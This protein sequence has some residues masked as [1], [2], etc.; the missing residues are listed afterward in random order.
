MKRN[1]LS[2]MLGLCLLC[3]G[4][5]RTFA[6][7]YED[8]WK[9]VK[10]YEKKDL[11]KSAYKVVQQIGAK[12]ERENVKGQ[13]LAALAHGCMLRQQIMP[14]SFYTDMIMLERRKE[15][16][17]DEVLR[18][19]Y[20]SVLGELYK[21]NARRNRN[22]GQTK[23]HPDSLREW[24]YDQFMEASAANYRLSM[25]HPEL[26]A[27]VKAADFVPF[28]VR[29]EDAVYFD[30]D[31]LNV[32]GRRAV[33]SLTSS[34]HEDRR[35]VSAAWYGDMLKVYRNK[36]NRRAELL[37]M[38]DSLA[39]EKNFVNFRQPVRPNDNMLTDEDVEKNVLQSSLYKTYAKMLD[40]FGDL[41]LSAQIYIALTNLP[42]TPALKVKWAEEGCRK[43]PDYPRVA[44]L[45]NSIA[46]L[47]NPCIR[48]TLP[49][50]VYPE[51]NLPCEV[52]HRNIRGAELRW[53]LM[54][55]T[56][57]AQRLLDLQR[58]RALKATALKS[59]K[60]VKKQRLTW[61]EA[62]AY[63][64]VRDTLPLEVP[65]I[66]GYVVVMRPDGVSSAKDEAVGLVGA[67]RL[68][69][70]SLALPD[71]RVKVCVVDAETGAPVPSATVTAKQNDKVY[72]TAQTDETGAAYFKQPDG[73]TYYSRVLN[74]IAVKGE[75]KYMLP[76]DVYERFA[77]SED[78]NH[79]DIEQLYTD[80]SI[81]RPGQ[82]VYVGGLCFSRDGKDEKAESGR[83]LLLTLH[84]AN[85]KKIAER[86]AKSDEMG[87]FSTDF[88]LP[89]T[90]LN[91]T[92]SV[93]TSR[94]SVRFTVE[95]YKRPTFDVTLQPVTGIF[96]AGDTVMLTGK[97][98]NLT[99]VPVRQ[100]RVTGSSSLLCW[101][102]SAY[103]P[104]GDAPLDTV[105]TND[106]G[107][108]VMPVPI[109]D[110]E[111]GGFR[112]GFRQAVRI[113]AMNGAGETHE[114]S[115]VLPLSKDG[116]CIEFQAP[117]QWEKSSLP[118]CCPKPVT[119]TGEAVKDSVVMTFDLFCIKADGH[120][121]AV[122]KDRAWPAEKTV[123]TVGF[124]TLPVGRYELALRAVAAEDTASLTHKF[125]LFDRTDARPVEG[126]TDWFHVVCDTI[127]PS[128]PGHLQVG[129][130]A[131]DVTLY[132]TLFCKD[133]VLKDTVYEFSDSVLK[134]KYPYDEAYGDGLQAHFVFVKDGK[135]YHHEEM[136]L[137]RQPERELRFEWTT[138]RDRLQPGTAETWKLRVLT[139]DSK[140]AS[141]QVMAAMYDASLDRIKPHRWYLNHYIPKSYPYAGFNSMEYSGRWESFMS[142]T[143]RVRYIS[144]KNFSFDD[145]S[146]GRWGTSYNMSD[147][148]TR[149][150]VL[151][152]CENAAFVEEEVFA[153]QSLQGAVAGVASG[154]KLMKAA[155][156]TTSKME[157]VEAEVAQDAD[158][159]ET[160]D[161]GSV[162]LR[163]NL[164]ETAFF[165]PRLTPD[166]SG[167]FTIAFT[168][169]ESL[170]EWKFM[171]LA[172]TKDMM[173]GIF[174][175]KVVAAKEV[176][177]QLHL[178]RFVRVGDRATLSASL[179]NLTENAL[180]GRVT[181][182]VFDP[183]TGKSLWKDACKLTLEAE[184]DTVV[185]FG[186]TPR[187]GVSLPACRVMFEAGS[188]TDGEQRYL[189]VLAD[190]EWLTQTLP[191][192]VRGKGLTEIKLDGLFQNNH[193]NATGR[194]LTV[195]YTANPLWYAVQALPSV[196]EP[197]TDDAVSLGAA[198]Y[199]SVLSTRLATQ[200]PQLKTVTAEW[201]RNGQEQLKSP[202]ETQE[203]LKGILLDETPWLTDA[204]AETR[205]MQ[206]LQQLFDT[207]RQNDLQR[208]FCENL[209]KLQ[210]SDGGFSWFRGM[211]SSRY[212]TLAVAQLF[213]RA[214]L[215]TAAQTPAVLTQHVDVK[216]MMG[217]LT[218]ELHE[219]VVEDR[220]SVREHKTH[221][222]SGHS[223]LPFLYVTGRCD[224][225]LIG[226]SARAD[227]NYAMS[228][229]VKDMHGLDM[230]DK[231]RAAT[232][233]QR[234]G[235]KNEAVQLVRSLREHLVETS[236]GTHLEYYSNGFY[237]SEQK[238]DTHVFIMEA[239][240]A[241]GTAG[242]DETDGLCRWLLG[243]KQ[244]QA[245][246]TPVNS[247]N[248]VYAL[249]DMQHDQLDIQANDE[250]RVLSSKGEEWIRMESGE[251]E[252]AGLGCVSSSVSGKELKR[253]AG[254]V[255]VNKA[256]EQPTAWGAAYAQ[257][258]LPLADIEA[259]A[260]GV[261]IRCEV[262]QTS[263]KVG[264]RVI[265]RYVIT[266]DRDYEYVC[267][268]AGRAACLEPVESRTGYEYD[269]GLG[270]YKEVRDAS[271]NYFF[272][273]LPKGTYVLESEQYVE[274]PGV[275]TLGAAKLNGVYAPEFS[276][277]GNAPVLNV[278][279]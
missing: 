94:G 223:W 117:E 8:L 160:G 45:K 11:P 128:V 218:A 262:S 31:L 255:A 44:M 222:Y 21:Q 270:Y 122:W 107:T 57:S 65:G 174:T 39:V 245:W 2:A 50:Q 141:A 170:T 66:G 91:G 108:F 48:F 9:Q 123:E 207:N 225:G 158:G 274:R 17:G 196:L 51:K 173:S 191:F 49:G 155:A 102:R 85:G 56:L 87:K 145:F 3:G 20:A 243:Q 68:K 214:G 73:N 204:E 47:Q 79:E 42:V 152:V 97:V 88:V 34:A 171:A 35:G 126:M 15:N 164:N 179:F 12:A 259:Q 250:V 81:Y 183:A 100:A 36:G 133:K 109:R 157:V 101:F 252:L 76:R 190:K 95:E 188:Y 136:L 127:S 269:N 228:V 124:G 18:A 54:P 38:L 275:Y 99:G 244:V 121:E 182:E 7:S 261:S 83:T 189:P 199:A 6:A 46:Q 205:R 60:L 206:S 144:Y 98:M 273:R 84:D 112:F 138:F 231:A 230:A 89:S 140:P 80:R 58:K 242:A 200:Y 265:L 151:S 220:K 72:A 258:M 55:S 233:M 256:E 237:T 210:N 159:G 194:R 248:A 67:T 161:F 211:R 69:M 64:D 59:G 166:E 163:E 175:D 139:P 105:Y 37:V 75:D 238:I 201:M 150:Q 221:L 32:I 266:A 142:Y 78:K 146:W 29:G 276:A 19:V 111:D 24:S 260:K 185:M 26:L 62:A 154:K 71:N 52:F 28:V 257:F 27:E 134:F 249:M 226:T 195:E 215:F 216:K 116:L 277:Y 198:L 147:M 271:T 43:Y 16:A 63:E 184:A 103:D 129:S 165:Y 113:L 181:I 193:P 13:Q 132:Y 209:G 137:M 77:Y 86:E 41:S 212:I 227:L 96:H 278:R 130:T 70:F 149:G 90:G 197:R 22:Y 153:T 236:A 4:V 110:A 125:I 104:D 177:A 93:R 131:R 186:Y 232:V 263:P 135:M 162:Q 192:T 14:D 168:L 172:H 106:E 253:G 115:L 180:K 119:M 187:E 23:A 169:P 120:R 241:D 208:G 224:D 178:P 213:G 156:A 143:G 240:K 53:Y 167:N 82:T 251:G 74:F 247:M 279:P 25:A 1:I 229:L 92:Y 30:G 176:M 272:E 264:D 235:R 254:V 114:A 219:M 246:S 217:Y 267:L 40:E 118:K 202:L 268:K 10:A 234:A 5:E 61:A 239:L 203:D 148:S 33:N